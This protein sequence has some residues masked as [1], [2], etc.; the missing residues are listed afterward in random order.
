MREVAGRRGQGQDARNCE[1]DPGERY[2]LAVAEGEVGD[3]GHCGNLSSARAGVVAL[4]DA[5]EIG[6]ELYVRDCWC[7][8]AYF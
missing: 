2:K 5:L 3:C 8:R 7:A 6:C 1:H 4:A